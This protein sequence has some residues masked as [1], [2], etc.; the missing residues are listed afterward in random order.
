[1][2]ACA[3]YV[4][5]LRAYPQPYMQ[6]KQIPQIH[7]SHSCRGW[8]SCQ[9]VASLESLVLHSRAAEGWEAVGRAVRTKAVS[10]CIAT[11]SCSNKS[12]P[13]RTILNLCL[14]VAP[15]WSK[16][17][18]RF[19]VATLES[20][21]LHSNSL[22]RTEMWKREPLHRMMLGKGHSHAKR[23]TLTLSHLIKNL[24]TC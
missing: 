24:G 18:P 14:R 11:G 12:R 15:L 8:S 1:M 3:Y 22:G 13:V 2:T 17:L 10:S 7:G 16:I 9:A 21:F 20:N 4:K 19:S 6:T 23:L 5:G